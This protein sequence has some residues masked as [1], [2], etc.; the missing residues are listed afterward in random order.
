MLELEAPPTTVQHGPQDQSNMEGD[1]PDASY[2]Q[3][4]HDLSFVL[5]DC[6]PMD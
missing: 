5:I 1:I 4:R 2:S 3:C 6:R